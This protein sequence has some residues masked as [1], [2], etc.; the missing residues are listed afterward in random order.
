MHSDFYIEYS[1]NSCSSCAC[2]D[3]SSTLVCLVLP[4]GCMRTLNGDDAVQNSNG[5]TT[6]GGV[7]CDHTSAFIFGY[8]YALGV[9]TISMREL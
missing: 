3:S 1:I 2:V 6:C 4:I 8:S 9:C 5:M 7:I